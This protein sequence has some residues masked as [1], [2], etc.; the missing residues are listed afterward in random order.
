[1]SNGKQAQSGSAARDNSQP[2]AALVPLP[3][4]WVA[5]TNWCLPSGQTL[6]DFA[7]RAGF[8]APLLMHSPRRAGKEL[9]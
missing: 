1:M 4:E 8:L 2:D 5:G 6:A 3:V 9:Q 7:L